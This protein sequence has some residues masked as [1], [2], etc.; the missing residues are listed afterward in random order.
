MNVFEPE[1]TCIPLGVEGG[2]SEGGLSAYLMAVSGT[3]DFVCLDAGTILSGLK[4]AVAK[5]AFSGIPLRSDPALSTEGS[6]LRHHVK[7]YLITHS[8]LDHTGGL[9]IIS[10]NDWSKP[11]MALRGVIDDFRDHIFNWRL[12]PNF[13]YS[14]PP[15]ILNKYT[16]VPLVPGEETPIPGASMTVEAHP[17]AHGIDADS[18]AFLIRHGDEYVLYMGDTGPD[19]VEGRQ[20]TLDL[21]R[22]IAPLVSA[23]RLRGIFIE[24]SYANDRPDDQLYSHLTPAW[25]FRSFKKLAALVD[26]E[27]QTGSRAESRSGSQAESRSAEKPLAGLKVVITHIKPDLTGGITPAEVVAGQ[28]K[29]GNDLGLD[30]AFARQGVRIDL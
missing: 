16:C 10:P 18:A 23:R 13:S 5:N 1:F 14:G 9:A 24:S 2:L 25:I 8:Y 17:L 4:I 22:R 19:E 12:W 6:I 3:S 30:I 26:S 7:A 20:T 28:L 27:N 15:P 29:A 11:I 21:W